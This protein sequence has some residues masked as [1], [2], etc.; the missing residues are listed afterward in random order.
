MLAELGMVLTDPGYHLADSA[1][2]TDSSTLGRGRGSSSTADSIGQGMVPAKL[3]GASQ[4]P[5]RWRDQLVT[6][7][8]NDGR[9]RRDTRRYR[10]R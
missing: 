8:V 9:A 6:L 1:G 3:S 5:D 2:H 7:P 10:S 4:N